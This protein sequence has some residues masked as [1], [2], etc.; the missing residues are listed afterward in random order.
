MDY[1][2]IHSQATHP[3]NKPKTKELNSFVGLFA[4]SNPMWLSD[5]FVCGKIDGYDKICFVKLNYDNKIE[6][7]GVDIERRVSSAIVNEKFI[8]DV[9]EIRRSIFESI[10]DEYWWGLINKDKHESKRINDR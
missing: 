10:G 8:E 2:Q 9:T 5:V 4:F 7:I 3:I 1:S 6:E